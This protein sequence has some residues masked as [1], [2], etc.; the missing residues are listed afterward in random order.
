MIFSRSTT[1]SL[2]DAIPLLPENLSVLYSAKEFHQELLSLIRTAKK[3][4]YLTALYLQDD[5]AGREVLHAIYQAKQ[6]NPELDVCLFVDFHRAQR[7][8]IGEGTSLGNRELYLSLSEQYEHDINIYGV[9]VKSRE[10][11]GVL[12]LKG[13]VVDD[14]LLFSGASI[15]NV[16]LHVG[17]KYRC[18]RY[19]KFESKVLSNTFVNYLTTYFVGNNCAPR[20]NQTNV[21]SKKVIKQRCK[22]FKVELKNSEY[23]VENTESAR[24]PLSVIPLVGLGP[25][26]NKLNLT[27]RKVFQVA[28]S[29]LVVFTPYF[30][31]PKSLT[32][33]LLKALKRGVNVTVIV[34]DKTANDF[35]IT[36]EDKFSTIGIVPYLY[37]RLLAI[38]IK[39]Y[40]KYIDKGLL[41]IRLWK[42]ESNSYHLKGVVADDTYHLI[43]GSNLNPRAWSLDLENGLLVTDKQQ[44]LKAQ[45]HKELDNILQHTNRINS[46]NDL[47]SVKDYPEKPKELLR[48]IKWTQIDRILKRFL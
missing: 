24:V 2:K 33:D 47:Q 45:W 46:I 23:K 35:Y 17:D 10:F 3:R 15:N 30:N 43:T 26:A 13:F 34:G 9:A 7:G 42:H 1:L 14:V 25:K 31:L 11:L 38:F 39:K 22:K 4:I 41:N 8:L 29:N 44:Q 37:E 20:I 5:D 28:N 12:H 32:A 48:R 19:H 36:D 18:D 21:P 16:Y 6:A 27:A 40:Q